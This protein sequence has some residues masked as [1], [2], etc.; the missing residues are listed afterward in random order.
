M[1][2]WAAVLLGAALATGT[3]WGGSAAAQQAEFWHYLGTGSENRAVKAL[4]EVANQRFPNTPIADRTI[5][6]SNIELRRALQLALLGGTP[7]AVYQSG[8]GHDLIN[9]MEGDRLL[10]VT[11]IWAEVQG[12]HIFPEGL[13]RVVTFQGKTWGVPLGMHVIT[14]VFYNKKMFDK[15]G[16]SPPRTWDELAAASAALR[17][18]GHHPIA[19]ASGARSWSFYNFFAPLIATVGVDGYYAIASGSVAYDTPEMRRAFALYKSHFV[20]NYME[21]WSGFKWPQAADQFVQGN[22]GMYMA[23][24]WVSAHFKSQGF[25]PGVDYDLFPAPGL[26]GANIVQ[27]DVLALLAGGSARSTEAGRNFLRAAATSEGQAAFNRLKGSVAANLTTPTDIYDAVG[28]KT[29]AALNEAAAAG[30][31]L[32]NLVFLL[33]V[34]LA[35]EF[36]PR[37]EKWAADPTAANLD[38]T[39]RFL[40]EMRLKLK[41]EGKFVVW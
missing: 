20:D 2:S 30:K 31:V 12:D 39:L 28:K 13:K 38:A 8:M 15:L 16:L 5:T 14:N 9:F 10:D 22:I 25:V 24:D 37:V 41:A 6:G 11:P 7:P 17:K 1:R 29:Y 33:P 4:V 32:P 27:V 3:M 18:A 36:G 40:E 34:T 26:D 19:N 21:N 35:N 23:G